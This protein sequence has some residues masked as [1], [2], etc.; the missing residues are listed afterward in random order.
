MPMVLDPGHWRLLCHPL[1][2]ELVD[3]REARY[4]ALP[5]QQFAE[6]ALGSAL[7][8]PALNQHAEHPR[9][10][11]RVPKPRRRP[12]NLD[13]RSRRVSSRAVTPPATPYFQSESRP[14]AK[15]TIHV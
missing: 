3:D 4:P 2:A 13:D 1:T 5:L 12:G 7:V 6:Q 15:L 11:G 8:T 14:A 10:V 9:S